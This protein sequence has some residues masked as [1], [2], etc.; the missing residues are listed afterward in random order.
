ME[1]ISLDIFD[2]HDTDDWLIKI[3]GIYSYI[4]RKPV[5]TPG[6]LELLDESQYEGLQKK[7]FKNALQESGKLDSMESR[8]FEIVPSVKVDAANSLEL[9][10]LMTYDKAYTYSYNLIDS[11]DF[12]LGCVFNEDAAIV[13]KRLEER[14]AMFNVD[15]SD[16][17]FAIMTGNMALLQ[18]IN[19]QI[20]LRLTESLDE[21]INKIYVNPNSFVYTQGDKLISLANPLHT[22]ESRIAT[23]IIHK[24]LFFAQTL[25]NAIIVQFRD[26]IPPFIE[27]AKGMLVSKGS[28]NIVLTAKQ[29]FTP[30]ISFC[31]GRNYIVLKPQSFRSIGE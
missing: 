19:M 31:C 6:V 1:E 5:I 17:S 14:C 21:Y 25:L 2:I 9:M 26:K 18:N 15:Y 8:Y 23:F 10:G 11:L 24:V 27:S 22:P 29:V 4:N 20:F 16:L 30:N 12:C 7:I 13:R 28:C 3:D